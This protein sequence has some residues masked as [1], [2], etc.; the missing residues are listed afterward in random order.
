MSESLP[1]IFIVLGSFL[2]V[3]CRE[4]S[5]PL[6]M[7]LMFRAGSRN[8][9]IFYKVSFGDFCPEIKVLELTFSRKSI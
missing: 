3:K 4:V 1:F 2:L 6:V 9:Y 8:A 7:L 5:C